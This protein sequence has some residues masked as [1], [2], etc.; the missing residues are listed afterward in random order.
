VVLVEV[1]TATYPES[2]EARHLLHIAATRAAHQLWL[3]G[4]GTP[5]N[6]IPA[7]LRERGY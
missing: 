6:L 5:S 3:T 4:T 1:N 7:L 2:E